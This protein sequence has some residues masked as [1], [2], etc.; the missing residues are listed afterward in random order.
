LSLAHALKLRA[1]G[2]KVIYIGL[3]GDKIDR[4]GE[5]Y[6]IFDNTF[7]ITSGKFRRYHGEGVLA[8]LLDIKTLLLNLVDAFKVTL[9]VVQAWRILGRVKPNA[10]FSKGGFVVVPAGI[11]AHWRKVAIVTH[12]SDTVPGLA[13]KIIGRWATI[14]ATGMPPENYS[15]PPATIRYVGIPVGD[16]V[17]PVDKQMQS[18]F[19]RELGIPIDGQ[20]I[21]AGGAGLGAKTIN[22][23]MVKVAPDLMEGHPKLYI[24]HITGA[25]HEEGVT[26]QYSHVLQP[27]QRERLKIMGFTTAFYKYTGAADVVITRAGATTL[28]EL[29]IQQ[30]ATILIPAPHLTG[31]HQIKNA[32]VLQ[33]LH[34]ALVVDNSAS[35]QELTETIEELLKD[36][37]LRKRLAGNIAKTGR[38][39]AA[40]ALADIL[41]AEATKG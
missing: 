20:L 31:G 12:D 23:L 32:Q 39:D 29:A 21:L 38:P 7:F 15:Y 3:K 10:F 25:D 9:G 28:A 16:R 5:E 4:L 34:A 6:E 35:P 36:S 26:D 19:K 1:P 33:D 37:A 18:E 11:A 30:K 27:Q 22:D 41:I 8:H 17:Q 2:T 13:N 40:Y 14:H 24:A